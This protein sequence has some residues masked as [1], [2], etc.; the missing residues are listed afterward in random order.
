MRARKSQ[1]HTHQPIVRRYDSSIYLSLHEHLVCIATVNSFLFPPESVVGFPG[2]T[3]TGL[4]AAA[5]QTAPAYPYNE[6]NTFQFPLVNPQ[7]HGSDIGSTFEIAKYMGN[8]SPWYSLRSADYGLPDASPLVP[9][10]CDI[11]QL[12]LL[13]RHGA[14]YPTSDAAPPVF[15]QKLANA[16]NFTVSGEL[17]FLANWTYKLGNE[18][19]TPFGRSQ[20]FLL[21]VAYRELYGHLLNNFTESGTLPVFRTQSQDRMVKTAENFAAGFFGVPEYLDQVSIE[22][23]VEN[24]TVNNS[25]APYDVCPNSNVKSRGSIGS[26]LA[27]EFASSAF[28]ATTA[29]LQSQVSQLPDLITR[30][31]ASLCMLTQLG[32]RNQLHLN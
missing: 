9:E 13:Y 32:S 25:G 4:Q 23:L 6:G 1:I 3:S 8:L 26:A 29:R 10:G 20:N 22:I 21:G 17:A 28:N 27:A 30:S 12:H 31:G 19:L 7:P 2:P 16:T 5:I 14:R 18:L 11:T 15:A 24:A